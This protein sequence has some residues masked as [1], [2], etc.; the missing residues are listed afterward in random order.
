M[1]DS[2]ERLDPRT[3]T[4]FEQQVWSCAFVAK[5]HELSPPMSP[6]DAGGWADAAVKALREYLESSRIT[7]RAPQ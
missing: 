6:S 4:I 5:R 7:N 3:L 1:H 2:K